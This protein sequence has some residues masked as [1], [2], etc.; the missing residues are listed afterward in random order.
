MCERTKKNWRKFSETHMENEYFIFIFFF[1]FSKYFK[2]FLKFSYYF[3]LLNFYFLWIFFLFT[4]FSRQSN[5]LLDKI[6]PLG[7]ISLHSALADPLFFPFVWIPFPQILHFFHLLFFFL[8]NWG[9]IDHVLHLLSRVLCINLN[10]G[11]TNKWFKG[12]IAHPSFFSPF[13]FFFL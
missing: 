13:V 11:A 7:D 9:L 4:L 2:I 3:I 5:V 12:Y 10:V 1:L 6:L 8:L